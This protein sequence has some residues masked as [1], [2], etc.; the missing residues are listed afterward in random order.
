MPGQNQ[1]ELAQEIASRTKEH[2]AA[3]HEPLLLS[4]L[5]PILLQGGFNFKEI[6]SLPI[7]KF[8]EQTLMDEVKIITHP[9]QAQKIGIIPKGENYVFPMVDAKSSR[10]IGLDLSIIDKLF[11]TVPISTV[12]DR[13]VPP[14]STPDTVR[15]E[16]AVAAIRTLTSRDGLSRKFVYQPDGASE[17]KLKAFLRLLDGLTLKEIDTISIPL[18]TLVRMLMP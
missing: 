17:E 10:K 8:I 9:I 7:K 11:T 4:Q 13:A 18:R 12:T 15:A 1:A 6:T 2:W 14:E 5:G 3:R 16:R